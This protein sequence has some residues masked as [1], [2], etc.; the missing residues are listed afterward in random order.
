MSAIWPGYTRQFRRAPSTFNARDY[1][2]A[3]SLS[4]VGCR[5]L[6]SA[7]ANGREHARA[8]A[9]TPAL[10]DDRKRGPSATRVPR[11]HG[12]ESAL[13]DGAD[14]ATG[15]LRLADLEVLP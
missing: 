7:F 9:R 3:P 11:S 13:R 8:A 4:P 14:A 2:L 6:T 5:R 12:S 15:R 1:R 10:D